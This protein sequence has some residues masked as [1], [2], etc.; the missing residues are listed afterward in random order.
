MNWRLIFVSL[1]L[2]VVFSS[3]FFYLLPTNEVSFNGGTN[4]TDSNFSFGGSSEMQYYPKM[5]FPTPNISYKIS[6]CPL[7]R[8]NEMENA[9]TTLESLTPLSFYS[10]DNNEEISITCQDK[11][12]VEG[13][14]FVAG[15]GGPTQV[16]VAGD[17]NVIMSG[18]ILLIRDSECPRPNIAIHELLHVL[19][20]IHSQNPANIMYNVSNCDQTI[21]DDTVNLLNQ[22]YSIPSSPDLVFGNASAIMKGRFLSLNLTLLNVGFADANKSDIAIYTDNNLVRKVDINPLGIGQ[23]M[24]LSISNVWISQLSVNEVE[25]VIETNFDEINKENNKIKLELNQN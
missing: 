10:V 4:Y 21:G 24:S 25:L 19:G 12:Q 23:G 13:G 17:F 8:A 3:L 16:I 1:I 20:F 9:F 6:G 22:L 2:L 7:Q 18:E 14:M 11:N 5:R 15:E